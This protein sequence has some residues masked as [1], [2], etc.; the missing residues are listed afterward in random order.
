MPVYISPRCWAIMKG[1]S[2]QMTTR[3]ERAFAGTPTG[4]GRHVGTRRKAVEPS[5]VVVA[6]WLLQWG[7]HTSALASLLLLHVEDSVHSDPDIIQGPASL[8]IQGPPGKGCGKAIQGGGVPG[9][10]HPVGQHL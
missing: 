6:S 8:H 9:L 2:P 4:A 10:P 7:V 5:T 3:G 1:H